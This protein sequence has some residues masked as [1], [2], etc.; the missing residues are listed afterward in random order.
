MKKKGTVHGDLE[1][2]IHPDFRCSLRNL[3]SSSCSL[4]FSGYTLQSFSIAF[5]I[6]SMAWSHFDWSGSFPKMAL[7]KTQLLKSLYSLGISFSF[8]SIFIFLIFSSSLLQASSR[9]TNST[10][11]PSSIASSSISFSTSF[12]G[13]LATYIF[14]HYC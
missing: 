5:S 2:Q 7:L 13:S 14:L 4:T 6:N 11:F 10:F 12:S 8:S 1:D 9:L 3:S